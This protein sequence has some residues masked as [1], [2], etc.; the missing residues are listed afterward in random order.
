VLPRS[1][2]NIRVFRQTYELGEIKITDLIAEQRRL[3]EASRDHAEAL[4][5][6]YQAMIDLQRA[7]GVFFDK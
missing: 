3:Q 4:T 2:Q 1:Q 5:D 7:M 6:R